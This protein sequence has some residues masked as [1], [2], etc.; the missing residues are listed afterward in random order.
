[1]RKFSKGLLTVWAVMSV[2][3]SSA[4]AG[5]KIN[6]M[7]SDTMGILGTYV[8][9]KFQQ[10]NPGIKITLEQ[11]GSSTG[12][13][14]MI[15]GT[16][17]LSQSSRRIKPSELKRFRAKYK[18]E[19]V[20]IPIALDGLVIYV[21]K[22][23]PVDKITIQ[24]LDAIF[25]QNPHGGFAKITAWGRL[26]SSKVSGKF[27]RAGISLYGRNAASGTYG[28]FKKHVLKRGDYDRNCKEM[29]G[30]A[31]VV[32]A[33]SK[34]IYGIGYGGIGYKTSAIKI[35]RVAPKAG[36]EFVKASPENVASGKYPISRNLYWYLAK[37]PAGVLTGFIRYGLSAAGQKLIASP[38][39][40]YIGLPAQQIEDILFDLDL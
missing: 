36:K 21:N 39:V 29:P 17:D 8:A 33:V 32:N 31:Q 9:E 24:E 37:K 40:G 38:Q 28:Y 13:A 22:K 7:G 20:E 16:C 3:F 25:G 18:S 12:I 34:D 35:L 1:M 23:N 30:T 4:Y 2:S 6:I 11:K 27:V 15:D 5:G 10:K 19:P 26:I 14:G